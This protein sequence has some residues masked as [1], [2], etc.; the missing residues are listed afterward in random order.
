MLTNPIRAARQGCDM[1]ALL[2]RVEN[3][4]GNSVGVI[5]TV[6]VHAAVILL[7]LSARETVEIALPPVTAHVISDLAT[8][9]Q[10]FELP[11]ARP[12]LNTPKVEMT[13]PDI[14]VAESSTPVATMVAT[15]V[16]NS[17]AAASQASEKSDMVEPRFDADYL[18]NPKP[19][20]PRLSRRH[21]EQGVV[22]LRVYVLPDGA[23][24]R[25][26]LKTSS[27][28]TLLDQAALEAVRRWKFVPAQAGGRAM[29]AWVNVPLEFSLS[30]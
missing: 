15:T 2:M 27:G 12:E 1:S 17:I 29:A 26:E 28:F 7:L 21:R 30:T 10:S 22:T 16:S 6:A 13:V 23:P 18:N 14:S 11:K 9:T 19:A 24:E 3:R 5:L 4:L 8:Q 20:Y 25:V